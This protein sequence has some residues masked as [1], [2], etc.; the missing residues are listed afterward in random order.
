MNSYQMTGSLYSSVVAGVKQKI[1][2]GEWDCGYMTLFNHGF[3]IETVSN[4]NPQSAIR[5]PQSAIRNP[6]ATAVEPSRPIRCGA[7]NEAGACSPSARP[8][9]GRRAPI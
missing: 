9:P 2:S 7:G 3:E 4:I 5:N 6:L 1:G 8:R